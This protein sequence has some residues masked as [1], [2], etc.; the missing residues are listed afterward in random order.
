VITKDEDDHII[1]DIIRPRI[2][3]DKRIETERER[4]ASSLTLPHENKIV[5]HLTISRRE[6]KATLQFDSEN[7]ES[8]TFSGANKNKTM[9]GRQANKVSFAP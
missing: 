9:S 7:D 2:T 5:S 3:K 8:I 4:D 6:E 1:I